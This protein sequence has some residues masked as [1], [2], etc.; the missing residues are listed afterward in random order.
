MARVCIRRGGD[1]GSASPATGGAEP[2]G[3][4]ELFGAAEHAGAA[5]PTAGPADVGD[6]AERTGGA[7]RFGDAERAGGSDSSGSVALFLF[8]PFASPFFAGST[9]A[10]AVWCSKGGALGI[11]SS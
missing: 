10:G 11:R 7:E 3:A 8:E 4:A 6:R 5:S 1:A 9:C 2:F